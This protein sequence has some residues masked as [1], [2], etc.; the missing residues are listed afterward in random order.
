MTALWRAG[1]QAQSADPQKAAARNTVAHWLAASK[2]GQH[3][4]LLA[5]KRRVGK[6]EF[7]S[8]DPGSIGI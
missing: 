5:T 3:R 7:G 2:D 1:S 6:L 8:D 4:R